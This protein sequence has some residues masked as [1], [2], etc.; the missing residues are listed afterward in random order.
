LV[1]AAQ[2]P[3]FKKKQ[4]NQYGPKINI[5]VVVVANTLGYYYYTVI[6]KKV[7]QNVTNFKQNLLSFVEV[8]KKVS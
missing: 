1:V 2:I 6:Q 5:V 3:K 8:M 7:R 4:L